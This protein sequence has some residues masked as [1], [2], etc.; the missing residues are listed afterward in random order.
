MLTKS[1]T[2]YIS[3]VAL[4]IVTVAAL[5]TATIDLASYSVSPLITSMSVILFCVPSFVVAR[6]WL[7]TKDAT[8]I[9]VGL[10]ILGLTIETFALQTGFPY[11]RFSYSE[12]AGAKLP[13]GAPW[14]VALGWVPLV[15]AAYSAAA[16]VSRS[17]TGRVCVA[18]GVLIAFDLVLDPGAVRVGLWSYPDGGAF[19]AVP[20]QNFVGWLIT[21]TVAMIAFEIYLSQIRPLL[22]IP[23]QLS[24]SG[25]LSLYFWTTVASFSGMIAPALTGVIVILGFIYLYRKY[26]YRFDDKVVIVDADDRPLATADKLE[27]HNSTTQ[28]HRAFSVF[29]F[30]ESGELLLQRRS[31]SKKTWPGVWS[32]SC[33]GH[34]MLHE[35]VVEA[36][37][38]R[39]R[40]ELGISRAHLINLVPHFAYRAEK[41]GIVEN[42]LCPIILA[43][44]GQIPVPNPEEVSEVRWT[45]WGDFAD[46]VSN[47]AANLS[48]WAQLEVKKM[49]E[50]PTFA[51]Y[52]RSMTSARL[53]CMS[54]YGP[55]GFA[56]SQNGPAS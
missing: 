49:S 22:P 44:S 32:N 52:L 42:E 46:D 29:L 53:H 6:R 17:R 14:T 4:S 43:F 8:I 1:R 7:G 54:S 36:A 26:Y 33:C 31:S 10:G 27:A 40:F 34:T 35:T 47:D 39:L 56:G 28:L 15:L 21:G 50:S 45:T 55:N 13:G 25:V 3:T 37:R 12:V 18:V 16:Q 30:N 9:F 24:A 41:D 19:Y 38:R 2:L 20:I 11:G 48:P 23:V 51:F 5:V